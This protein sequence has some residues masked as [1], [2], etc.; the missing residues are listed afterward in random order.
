MSLTKK[1][2][3]KQEILS[4][5]EVSQRVEVLRRFKTLLEQ[6]RSKFQEY[7]QVLEAQEASI[8]NDEMDKIIQHAQLGQ[9]IISDISTIQKVI[10]PLENMCR[11]FSTTTLSP[12]QAYSLSIKSEELETAQI[13]QS[14]E[15]LKHTVLAQNQKN[16]EKLKVHMAGLRNQI[17]R[18]KTLQK[19]RSPFSDQ[20][21]AS[22][23]DVEA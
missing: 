20:D 1:Q 17:S 18:L 6:Q 4:S 23:I 10:D 15:K 14:L 12:S 21:S 9:A 5:A 8:I 2:N 19:S 7:L 13:K 3:T 16:T 22:L 11:D